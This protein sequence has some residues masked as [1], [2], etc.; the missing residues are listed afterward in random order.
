[1]QEA[2]LL[3]VRAFYLSER[4]RTPVTILADQMVTDGWETLELPE[5]PEEEQK[6]GWCISLLLKSITTLMKNSPLFTT[7]LWYILPPACVAW[8]VII[9]PQCPIAFDADGSLIDCPPPHPLVK[10]VHHMHDGTV[11]G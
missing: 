9:G 3:T 2:Y 11:L 4:F 5:S 8:R 6:M 10:R 7:N 1:M